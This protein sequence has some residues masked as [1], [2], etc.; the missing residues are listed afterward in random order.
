MWTCQLASQIPDVTHSALP[1]LLPSSLLSSFPLLSLTPS[2]LS[3][4]FRK[5]VRSYTLC[6]KKLPGKVFTGAKSSVK[7][8][9]LTKQAVAHSWG[10]TSL[11]STPDFHR[12]TQ[13]Y[14]WLP[15]ELDVWEQCV[16]YPMA[17]PKAHDQL[18]WLPAWCVMHWWQAQFCPLEHEFMLRELSF[19]KSTLSS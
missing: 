1:A 19:L 13:D 9:A 7:N 8:T 3:L 6:R 18:A 16:S 17:M 5:E 15:H 10:M 4:A 12:C 11:E 2:L 14:T